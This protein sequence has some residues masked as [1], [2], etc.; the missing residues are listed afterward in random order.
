MKSNLLDAVIAGDI[1]SVQKLL[2]G[3][4]RIDVTNINGW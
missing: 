3:G 1:D 4:D 2:D